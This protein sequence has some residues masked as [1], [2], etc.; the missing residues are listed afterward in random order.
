[1]GR[2]LLS[3]P[4][5]GQTEAGT[6]FAS[7]RWKLGETLGLE[8]VLGRQMGFISCAI[9]DQVVLLPGAW[10]LQVGPAGKRAKICRYV[11]HGLGMGNRA[12]RWEGLSNGEGVPR[13]AGPIESQIHTDF[14]GEGPSQDRELTQAAATR[15]AGGGGG[16]RGLGQ[17]RG[18]WP[19]VGGG[20]GK[21][22]QTHAP[23]P[24]RAQYRPY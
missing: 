22:I 5:E 17:P 19:V 14:T 18:F 16:P 6:V 12:G 20:G 11:C 1:M 2:G 4:A 24:P 8:L 3:H 9:C 7:R 10:G 13:P 21:E 23:T 15:Q